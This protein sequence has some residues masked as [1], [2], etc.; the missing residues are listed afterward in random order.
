MKKCSL[1]MTSL[2]FPMRE[3]LLCIGHPLLRST[4]LSLPLLRASFRPTPF[5]GENGKS[6]FSYC[7]VLFYIL[8][9]MSVGRKE[10]F[11]TFR[12]D[13]PHNDTIEENKQ[14]LKQRLLSRTDCLL[15][16]L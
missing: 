3:C 12:R 16:F 10:A 13:Y 6:C 4:S 11:E 8:D 2:A 5:L 15:L 9:E 7:N 14:T 1:H